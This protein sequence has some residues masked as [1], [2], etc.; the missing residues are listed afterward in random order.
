M[1]SWGRRVLSGFGVT[2]ADVD[3]Y[4]EHA[5][6]VKRFARYLKRAGGG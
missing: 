1:H 2:T 3:N 4:I 6:Y 5:G